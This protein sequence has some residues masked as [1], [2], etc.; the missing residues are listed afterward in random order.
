MLPLK[1]ILSMATSA[2][3]TGKQKAENIAKA[4]MNS[5]SKAKK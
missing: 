5:S 2:G 1:L 4:F 3:N